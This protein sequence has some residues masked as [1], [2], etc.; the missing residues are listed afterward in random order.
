MYLKQISIKAHGPIDNLSYSFRE[1]ENGNPVPL[2]IIGKNGCGKTLLFSNIVDMFVEMKRELYPKGILEVNKNNYYKV[3]NLT[4]IKSGTR[5][6]EV[7]IEFGAS[8]K[9]NYIYRCDV[10]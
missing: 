2:V 8:D 7:K 1:D 5:T 3:G 10:A 6:S 9:K 4:Y